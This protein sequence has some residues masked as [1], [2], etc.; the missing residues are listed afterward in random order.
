MSLT[1]PVKFIH[2]VKTAQQHA[3]ASHVDNLI[4]N[5]THF[6][7]HTFYSQPTK[8]N[9]TCW[10]GFEIII[11]NFFSLGSGFLAMISFGT[12]GINFLNYIFC[13]FQSSKNIRNY[14]NNICSFVNVGMVLK[15]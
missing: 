5:L 9:A 7:A 4:E 10:R 2:C 1:R 6:T 8:K 3:F 13:K 11:K 15:I 14:C 12:W